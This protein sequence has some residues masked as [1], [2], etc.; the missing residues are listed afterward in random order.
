MN[1]RENYEAL[2]NGRETE[3]V[4]NVF[5]EV[6]I[7]G[8]Q[9][10][11]WENGPI[12]GGVDGFGCNWIPTESAGG[13]P[14]L[15]PACI[16]L[17]DVCDWEDKVVFPNL[18]AIDWQAYAD[19][20]LA[21]VDRSAK[22]V[23]YHTWNS[24]YLRFSHLLGFENALCAFFEEPE[25]S[26]AL[27]D[28]IAD[29]KIK[30]I[31]RVAHYIKPDAYVHYDDVATDRDLFMSPEV[32][33]EFIKPGHTRMN[34]AAAALGILPEIHVCGKCESIIPDLIEEGSHAW[35]SAQ[36]VN[37]L[38]SIIQNYGDKIA[39][40]GGYDTNGTPSLPTVSDEEIIAEVRRCIDTYG[41]F[42]KGYGFF[43]FLLGSFSDPEIAHRYGIM[44]AEAAQYAGAPI[45][46]ENKGIS[47]LA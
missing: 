38:E 6:A 15:D 27:C 43:G 11:T 26:K 41:R 45:P 18:D 28:A 32:Y 2:V 36:P 22:F 8:G 30:L 29:Y 16:V 13:Q 25:A 44:F 46:I 24:V 12:E 42:G 19:Q 40:I 37:D 17:D 5:T 34:E 3:W 33:R 39:V 1:Q 10:E 23:E 35:Q 20:M 14:A 4:P 31:E 9:F 47:I 21:G 7:L